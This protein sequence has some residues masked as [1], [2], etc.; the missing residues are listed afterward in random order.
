MKD[1][2]LIAEFME[3]PKQTDVVDDRTTAYYIGEVI[4]ANNENNEN[5]DDVFHPDDMMFDCSWDWLIPVVQKL[6]DVYISIDEQDEQYLQ[7]S[8]LY[9]RVGVVHQIVVKLIK[10]YNNED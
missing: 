9:D 4:K 1:N 10:L 6:I 5:E 8:I 3:F 7:Q 2:K